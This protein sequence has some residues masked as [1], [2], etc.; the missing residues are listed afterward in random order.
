MF[1]SVNFML[2]RVRKDNNH[3]LAALGQR[4]NRLGWTLFC[5]SLYGKKTLLDWARHSNCSKTQ[6]FIELDTLQHIGIWYNEG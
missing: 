4:I 6:Y 2:F 1:S 3:G 5:V